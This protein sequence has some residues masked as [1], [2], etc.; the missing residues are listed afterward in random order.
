MVSSGTRGS[1]EAYV[2]ICECV[3]TL[4]DV[5]MFHLGDY[6]GVFGGDDCFLLFCTCSLQ[7]TYFSTIN[8]HISSMALP[9]AR[10]LSYCNTTLLR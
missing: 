4:C 9:P 7:L 6:M 5:R 1:P 10:T 3:R 2:L 8:G